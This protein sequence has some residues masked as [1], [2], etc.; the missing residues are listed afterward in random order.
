MGYCK[1]KY[2]KP[3]DKVFVCPR[4]NSHRVFQKQ[5]EGPY[6]YLC[7]ACYWHGVSPII[8]DRAQSK[9]KRG[10]VNSVAYED[11]IKNL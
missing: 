4:C 10:V 9:N 6:K 8:Q 2:P 5:A 3:R 1:V 7:I 11:I